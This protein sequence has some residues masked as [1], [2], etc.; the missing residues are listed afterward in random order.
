M[1]DTLIKTKRTALS[2]DQEFKPVVKDLQEY[3]ER[4]TGANSVTNTE[5]FMLC[6]AVG[7]EM[8]KTRPVPP[9]KSD[10]VRISYLKEPHLAIMRSVAL[11]HSQDHMILMNEDQ[12][13]DVVEQY[14][15]GGLEILAVEMKNQVNFPAYL[16]KFLH[17][18]LKKRNLV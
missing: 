10:A 11:T 18:S 15:A 2:W 14:A 17:E 8:N 12:I 6:L 7:F 13:Y 3:L 4:M 9:K 1:T 16:V 5:L